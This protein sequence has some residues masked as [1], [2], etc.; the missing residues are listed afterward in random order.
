VPCTDREVED[1]MLDFR[2][3]RTRLGICL[4]IVAVLVSTAPA[5]AQV[6]QTQHTDGW[7]LAAAHK[8]GAHGSIWRT[9]L[10]IRAD[11]YS[12]GQVLLYFCEEGQDNTG[13][14]PYEV[15]ITDGENVVYI[16]DVVGHFLDVGAPGW[17][18]AIH[19]TASPEVQVYARVYSVSADGTESYGQLIEGIPTSDM[20]MAFEEDD[21]PGTR[22]DQW[23]F[24]LKHTADERYRANIGVVNPTDVAGHFYISVFDNSGDRVDLVEFDMEPMSM[25]QFSDPFADLNGGEWS[26]LEVRVEC[27][28]VGGGV[29]AYAS[30]VDNNTNDAYF[31]RGVKYFRPD[32]E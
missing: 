11:T 5:T 28:T 21:Y 29:F 23:L 2:T 8:A 31:V 30:V 7:I 16:E 14:T 27:E 17:V 10:W 18:G 25:E 13:V 12:T 6:N 4:G 20:S 32:S 19:Y 3:T 26:E 1:I 24:A 22:E 9:D 15:D